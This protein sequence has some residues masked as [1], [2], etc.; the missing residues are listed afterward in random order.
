MAKRGTTGVSSREP[1]CAIWTSSF[2]R[3]IV[4]TIIWEVGHSQKRTSLLRRA[5]MWCRRYN[6]NIRVVILL[7]YLRK[8]PLTDNSSILEVYRPLRRQDGK[9]TAVKDGPTY[10]LFPPPPNADTPLDSIPL[11]YEDYFGSGNWGYESSG[12]RIDPGKRSDLPLSLVR[13][14]IEEVVAVTVERFAYRYHSGGSSVGDN[15]QV[16][17]EDGGEDGEGDETE[18]VE[19]GRGSPEVQDYEE[20]GDDWDAAMSD[21][22]D[23]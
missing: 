2:N 10:A 7:K 12:E 19:E 8:N 21:V 9:W 1:D 23:A 5:K 15:M 14:R 18:Q 20:F 4:P 22:S 13:R 17:V 11:T 6:G 3:G 16:A